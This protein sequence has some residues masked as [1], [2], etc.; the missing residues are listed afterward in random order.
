MVRCYQCYSYSIACCSLFFLLQLCSAIAYA[1]PPVNKP[2]SGITDTIS[3]PKKDS[4]KKQLSL[5]K[6]RLMAGVKDPFQHSI[7]VDINDPF[8]KLFVTRPALRVNGGMVSYIGNY[9]SV[10]DTPYAER[11]ILQHNIT[12]RWDV[13]VAGIFPLQVN[14]WLRQSNSAFFR[15]IYDVQASFNGAAF[16]NNVRAS[17]R[18]RLMALAPS[19]KDSLF[20]KM[21]ALKQADLTG[22]ENTLKTTFSE[23]KL[24][25]ANETLKVP[26]LTWDNSLP[27]SVN[28]HR[29]DS[30]KGIAMD[31][32][33]RYNHTKKRY[34]SLH[35]RV[36]SLQ[37]K[38]RENL[39]KVKQYRQMI[40]GDWSKMQSVRGWKNMLRE[41]GMENLHL[42]AKYRWLLGIRHFSL[43]RSPVNYSELTAKN[44]SVNGI[45]VEYNSWYYLALSAGSVNYRFR[46][47]VVGSKGRK[48]QY[49][50]MVRAGIGRLEKD[51]FILSAFKGQKQLFATGAAVSSTI[52]IT[53]FSAESRWAVNRTT[54]ITAEVA[55]SMTPDYRNNPAQ[56]SN[57][58][59]LKDRNNQAVAFRVNSIIPVTQT[60]LEAFFK[61]TGANYQSF[62]SYTTNAAMESWYIKAGQNLFRRQLRIAG[63]LRKNEFSNPFLVQDY[64]SNTLFKSVTATVRVRRWPVVTVGYQ[65]LSQYTKVDEV[66]IENRFQTFNATLFHLYPVRQLKMATTVMFNKY[67]NNQT[68]TGFL[69]YNATNSY[70]TQTFYFN[71]F[72]AN[73]GISYTK[74][75]SYTLQVLDGG[76]QPNIPKL[77]TIGVGI[78]INNLN[79]TVIKAGGYVSANI[80]LFKQDMLFITYEH[81]YL[82]GNKNGL[83]RNEMGTIQFV[84]TFNFR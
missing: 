59:V 70:F 41:Y 45:N 54:Y 73:A 37:E 35:A 50:A 10:I 63:S 44:V 21:Y 26:K 83:V 53:G 51:Y 74:N 56:G 25:E 64:K 8:K 66:V 75:G 3:I 33:D 78:R 30:L 36:D 60:R 57:K 84:K 80:R 18:G 46:D 2:R 20:E 5:A 55:K 17:L 34:D 4:V 39:Q 82:P 1:Q 40:D 15:N 48:P 16:Q 76:I 69:Y 77:G 49:L 14:Y 27:D 43:G 9:R 61:Q 79:N 19:I 29:E 6:N 47:F 71:S 72:T 65:P 7:G 81:G 58:F 28:M 23:Q 13:T 52:N 24:I 68:D 62:S 67:Y 31:F 38:Y 22:L 42:P 11:H 32:I 12:G